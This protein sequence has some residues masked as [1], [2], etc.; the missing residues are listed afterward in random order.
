M[1]EQP[2]CCCRVCKE[3]TQREKIAKE[4]AE[5]ALKY[6]TKEYAIILQELA[7]YEE[8]EKKTS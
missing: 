5:E 6:L 7:R 1:G 4:E 3:N 8:E 2:N